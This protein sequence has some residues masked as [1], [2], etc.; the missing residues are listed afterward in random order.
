MNTPV[1]S[2]SPE[3]NVRKVN[4]FGRTKNAGKAGLILILQSVISA[5]PAR[6]ADTG[7]P[8]ASLRACRRAGEESE[9][10]RPV[11]AAPA[12]PRRRPAGPAGCPGHRVGDSWAGDG[13]PVELSSEVIHFLARTISPTCARRRRATGADICNCVAAGLMVVMQYLPW[14]YPFS[15]ERS[16]ASTQHR[17]P[18]WRRTRRQ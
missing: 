13:R 8:C 1:L 17:P 11:S 3:L 15:R 16:E 10:T 4:L 14:R 6:W 2:I 9:R 7:D 5:D 18:P 12:D